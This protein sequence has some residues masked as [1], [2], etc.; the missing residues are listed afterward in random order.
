MQHY[1]TYFDN[2]NIHETYAMQ[3]G[4][5]QGPYLCFNP[6]N[7]LI[8]KMNYHAGQLNGFFYAYS[9]DGELIQ[10]TRYKNNQLHGRMICYHNQQIHM[11]TRYKNHQE[12]GV[13]LIVDQKKIIAKQTYQHSKLINQILCYEGDAHATSS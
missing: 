1:T 9:D 10:W 13:R 12:H 8:V 6:N 4:K 3:D 5:L 7:V 2:G 11:I